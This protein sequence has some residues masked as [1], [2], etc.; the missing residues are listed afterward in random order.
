MSIISIIRSNKHSLLFLLVLVVMPFL[1][2]SFIILGIIRY[3]AL[4]HD[5]TPLQ[6]VG[7]YLAASI[8]M[9]FALTHTTFIALLGGFFLGWISM[10]YMLPAYIVASLIGYFSARLIDQGTFIE[11]ISGIKG[12]DNI[13]H[14][15]KKRENLVIF[16]CRISPILPFAMMNALLSILRASISKYIVAGSAGMLPRTLLFVWLGMQARNI[17][18]LIEHPSDN[19]ASKILFMALL[20][21]SIGGLFYIFKKIA[22]EVPKDPGTF[23]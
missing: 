13:I 15:L 4:I 8:T 22:G 1:A 18:E 7:L 5:F 6:W 12:V 20:I 17:K 2:S 11:S 16:F 14:N 21:F 10:L 9:A 23:T 19:M 3:E